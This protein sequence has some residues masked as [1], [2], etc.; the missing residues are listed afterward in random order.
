MTEGEQ[1]GV[2]RFGMVIGLRPEMVEQYKDLHAGPGVRHLLRQANIRNFC[3]YLRKLDDGRCLEFAYF[4][5]AGSDYTADMAWLAAQPDNQAWLALCD[6]MQIP[7]A[8]ETSWAPMEE[9]FFNL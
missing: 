5:Y 1:N 3:I 8:G 4:E 7:L 9:I 6:P 2:R